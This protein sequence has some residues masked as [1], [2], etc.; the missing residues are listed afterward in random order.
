MWG[1]IT[2]LHHYEKRSVIFNL[3]FLC[4][5]LHPAMTE[6]DLSQRQRGHLKL[7]S[8]KMNLLCHCS[9]DDVTH[10]PLPSLSLPHFL[11]HSVHLSVPVLGK[12]LR[13][14]FTSLMLLKTYLAA[15]FSFRA[16][17][18]LLVSH[19][20][21]LLWA[22]KDQT[23]HTSVSLFNYVFL[24]KISITVDWI[25][26]EYNQSKYWMRLQFAAWAQH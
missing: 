8:C 7:V 1:I 9:P 25:S 19:E 23:I 3:F 24:N 5:P 2:A 10:S 6:P 11:L 13:F 17:G 18:S 4:A 12:T 16:L 21:F 26:T 15:E 20:C 22:W 14:L